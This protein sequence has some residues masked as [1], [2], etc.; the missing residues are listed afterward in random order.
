MAV[1]PLEAHTMKEALAGFAITLPKLLPV[2]LSRV[3]NRSLTPLEEARPYSC[4][5]LGKQA[6]GCWRC[7]LVRVLDL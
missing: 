2:G 5:P 6:C 1:S 4:E 3:H 7:R